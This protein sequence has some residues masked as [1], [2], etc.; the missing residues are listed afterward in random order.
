MKQHLGS[1]LALVLGV[2]ALISGLTN[3]NSL[4][5]AGPITILGALSFR[6][7]KNRKLGNVKDTN[8]R[9]FFEIG[10]ISVI[11]LLFF[12]QNDLR[13]QIMTNPVPTFVIPVWAVVV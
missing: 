11:G 3:Q 4:L 10:A 8:A 9:K 12:M 2:L 7:A 13:F 1:T 6:S 5:I